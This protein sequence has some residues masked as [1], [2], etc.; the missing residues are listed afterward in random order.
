MNGWLKTPACRRIPVLCMRWRPVS[1]GRNFSATCRTATDADI[2][3]GPPSRTPLTDALSPTFEVPPF[4]RRAIAVTNLPLDAHVTELLALVHTGALEHVKFS[5]GAPTAELSFLAAHSAARFVA[6]RPILRGR[7]LACAWLP[8]RPLHPVIAAAAG[9]DRARRALVL[10]KARERRD[11]WSA[12]RLRT[13]FA[14]GNADVADLRV[15][16]VPDNPAYGEVAL[17]QLTDISAAIR[18]HARIRADPAMVHVHVAYWPDPCELPPDA[19]PPSLEA[20][21]AALARE[22][23]HA[24]TYFAALRPFTALTLH[25]LHPQTNITD[26]AARVFGGALYALDVRSD[27]TATVSFFRAEDARDFYFNATRGP[28]RIHDRDIAVAPVYDPAPP[29][30]PSS[31]EI[32][33][34]SYHDSPRAPEPLPRD[35]TR[36]VAVRV[37]NHPLLVLTR[38]KLRADFGRFGEIERVWYHPCVLFFLFAPSFFPSRGIPSCVILCFVLFVILYPSFFLV[39]Q[40]ARY[41][42]SATP[43]CHNPLLLLSRLVI[44]LLLTL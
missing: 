17:V 6:A 29:P 18:T 42:L 10:Y 44:L 12:P 8:Y 22:P 13:Y 35:Y 7:P 11:R 37:F 28:L 1:H 24:P 41:T 25:N 34:P 43:F 19:A 40:P 32:P 14:A 39:A 20:I 5:P 26:L 23:R 2:D 3:A 33:H 27:C 31:P 4:T 36:V 38:A 30:L 16:R 9:R 21:D 15:L